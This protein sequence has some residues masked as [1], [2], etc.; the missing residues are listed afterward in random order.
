MAGERPCRSL[1][2]TRRI[3]APGASKPHQRRALEVGGPD[4]NRTAHLVEQHGGAGHVAR[5]EAGRAAFMSP[6]FHRCERDHPW[7]PMNCGGR[8][9][10]S[11]NSI[12]LRHR[13]A[14]LRTQA[15]CGVA[16]NSW[17]RHRSRTCF[18]VP[19]LKAGLFWRITI[20]AVRPRSALTPGLISSVS[21][22]W[23]GCR[24]GSDHGEAAADFSR[25]ERKPVES[26]RK[27]VIT[28][29]ARKARHL[30]YLG[31]EPRSI[32]ANTNIRLAGIPSG[33]RV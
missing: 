4:V 14:G 32:P 33:Y 2:Q 16:T 20:A 21:P 31:G 8:P 15:A 19:L 7:P 26:Q 12:A 27:Q 5:P 23:T 11:S 9:I 22:I 17:G 6:W 1:F 30:V 25:N 24:A 13:F 28:R 18:C 10:R 3:F 29:V